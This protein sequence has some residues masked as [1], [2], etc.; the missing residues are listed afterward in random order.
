MMFFKQRVAVFLLTLLLS[1]NFF[2]QGWFKAYEADERRVIS[3]YK[4]YLIKSLA[5]SEISVHSS[6]GNSNIPNF[7]H[8]KIS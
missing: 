3:L 8:F 1:Q 2:N 7:I 5:S 6:I 4:S